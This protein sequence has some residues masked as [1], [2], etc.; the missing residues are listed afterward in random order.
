[1]YRNWPDADK[2]RMSVD[3]SGMNGAAMS[4]DLEREPH[5]VPGKVEVLLTRFGWTHSETDP[6]TKEQLWQ[7]QPP[8]DASDEKKSKK[9]ESPVTHNNL[10]PASLYQVS[11]KSNSAPVKN[12]FEFGIS[13]TL[14]PAGIENPVVIS[15]KMPPRAVMLFCRCVNVL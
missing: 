4:V 6:N 3:D 13:S 7:K 15:L 5:S 9:S 2:I 10:G 12:T 11:I 14:V 8:T 1:M